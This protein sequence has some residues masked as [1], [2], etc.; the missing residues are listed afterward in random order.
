M[1]QYIKLLGISPDHSKQLIEAAVNLIIIIAT[2]STSGI[3]S[4]PCSLPSIIPFYRGRNWAQRDEMTPSKVLLRIGSTGN[5][6]LAILMHGNYSVT[7]VGICE[8]R[9]HHWVPF[10]STP[11]EAPEQG[12]HDIWNTSHLTPNFHPLIFKSLAKSVRELHGLWRSQGL[13]P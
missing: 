7:P 12:S 2:G 8:G 9:W 1:K 5:S 10:M 4:P 13:Q 3:Y 6:Q 11:R